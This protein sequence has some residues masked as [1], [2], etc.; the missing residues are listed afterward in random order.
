MHV[1][2]HVYVFSIRKT[3]NGIS[4]CGWPGMCSASKARHHCSVRS[5]WQLTCELRLHILR[6]YPYDSNGAFCSL[7]AT[8]TIGTVMCS[9][10]PMPK[11]SEAPC[12]CGWTVKIPDLKCTSCIQGQDNSSINGGGG[13]STSRRRIFRTVPLSIVVI[14][15]VLKSIS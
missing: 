1:H 8:S 10:A 15:I 11:C 3:R 12:C 14:D 6:A 4:R 7:K 13:G 9:V 2:K 5:R